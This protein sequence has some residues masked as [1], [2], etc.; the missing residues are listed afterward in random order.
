[1]KTCHAIAM[2]AML[3]VVGL[4]GGAE[5]KAAAP[6][7]AER[8]R[9]I[10]IP[11]MKMDEGTPA[12]AIRLLRELAVAHDPAKEGLGF[13]LQ[14]SPA[15]K[16]LMDRPTVSFDLSRITLDQ[17]IRYVCMAAGLHYRFDQNAVIL[18]DVPLP[19]GAFETRVY[20]LAPGVL[21]PRPTRP[22]PK[23]ID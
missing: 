17:A 7:A 18:S 16:A 13:V 22:K 19:R 15:G 8:A 3:A 11:A 21:K 9:S 14:I 23:K 5:E 10:L 1:M 12:E 6:G 4:L 2:L 20:D